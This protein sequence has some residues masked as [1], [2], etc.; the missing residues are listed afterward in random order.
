[1]SQ[2]RATLGARA[3]AFTG[4]VQNLIAPLLTAG[5]GLLIATPAL[6]ADLPAELIAAPPP[7]FYRWDGAYAGLNLGAMMANGTF[8]LTGFPDGGFAGLIPPIPA[9]SSGSSVGAAG[10]FQYGLR[11]QFDALVL[12]FEQDL[13]LGA[14]P[15][16]ADAHGIAS[17]LSYSLNQSQSADWLSTLRGSIGFAPND[18]IMVYATGGLA[19]GVMRSSSNLTLGNGAILART[20]DD[21]RT[22]WAAGVGGEYAL[23]PQISARLEYLYV[24]LGHATVVGL[25]NFPA[26][27]ETHTDAGYTAHFVRAGL[28]Y[29]FAGE[30]D[31]APF[32]MIGA[33]SRLTTYDVE[34]GARYWYST[35]STTK[36]LYDT[37]GSQTVSRLTYDGLTANSGEVFGRF[38][39]RSGFFAKGFA[40][41]G[42]IGS[43]NLKD[44]DFTPFIT[45]YSATNS[46]QRDG[47]L[48]Y[49]SGDLG[50]NVLQGPTY[51]LGAF[52]G[53][54]YEREVLNAHG[55]TQIATN[56][57]VCSPSISDPTL[58]ITNDARWTAARIGVNGE[59]M[60]WNRVT[61]NV[62]AAWLPYV[63]LQNSDAHWLR[64]Q[65]IP[66]NFNG[67]IP[68]DGVGHNGLQLEAVV[69]YLITP[70]FSVGAGARYW[71]METDGHSHFEDN[72]FGFSAQPQAV[73][74]TT[75][76]YGGFLQGAFKY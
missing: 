57:E 30:P 29:Q 27:F 58:G 65:P 28:N 69:S 72:I 52:V 4:R 26:P 33:G 75:E 46:S 35:G 74:F 19:F 71:H 59:V 15:V 51:K 34:I 66:G 23:T 2:S 17:G 9:T 8:G 32:R 64:M 61:I 16:S 53:V 11:R 39:D 7:V 10:G 31:G 73:H 68:E 40:G 37:T 56:P 36:T 14:P 5:V 62:D 38:D 18:E 55:C 25:P 63:Q 6:P 76:R 50:Y 54:F 48:A 42:A 21:L 70:S 67:P 1:M 24:D 20:S 60:L 13:V 44:E 45:P 47:T 22:G 12:G 49:A 3:I 43:G 41:V